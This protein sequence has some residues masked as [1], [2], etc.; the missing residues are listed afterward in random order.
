MKKSYALF[1][2]LATSNSAVAG[3]DDD[4]FD[5]QGFS[6][7]MSFMAGY[8]SEKSNLSTENETKTGELNSAG[9]SESNVMY[10]PMGALKYTFGTQ[11]IF[12]GMADVIEGVSA[13]ELGYAL[14]LGDR[15]ILSFSYLPTLMKGEVWKDPYLLNTSRSTTDLSGNAYRVQ[16]QNINDMGIDTEFAYYDT[17]I[18]NEFSG[19]SYSTS[20]QNLLKR[21]G[22]GYLLGFSFGIPLAD[23]LFLMPSM[24]YHKFNA[25]GDAMAFDEYTLGASFMHELDS[26]QSIMLGTEL[27]KADYDAT[28]PIFNKSREDLAYAINLSYEYAEFLGYKNLGF[29]AMTGYE[30]KNSNINFYDESGYTFGVGVNYAF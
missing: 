6:G 12:V 4:P 11:Q 15:S 22:N 16:W 28:N 2:I 23:S 26:R 29:S 20:T 25:D 19:S 10:A 5:Q 27:S 7:E 30:A 18:D 1:T 3:M 14:E 13:I 9:K 24:Q 21:G 8:S 17:E